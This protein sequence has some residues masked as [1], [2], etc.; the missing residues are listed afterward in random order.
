MGVNQCGIQLMF[1]GEA[2]KISSLMK[3]KDGKLAIKKA[4]NMKFEV[5][6]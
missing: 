4:Y 6:S 2:D 5:K 3:S 1:V